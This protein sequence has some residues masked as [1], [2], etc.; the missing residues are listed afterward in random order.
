MSEPTEARVAVYVDFD[1][2]VISRY[3]QLLGRG[4]FQTAHGAGFSQSM[5]MRRPRSRLGYEAPV[6]VSSLLDYDVSLGHRAAG[7]TPTGRTPGTAA[8]GNN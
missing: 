4:Q 3:N 6:D 8:I 2:I 7:S 1:N 5:R